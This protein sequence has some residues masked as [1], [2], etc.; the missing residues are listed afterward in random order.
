MAIMFTRIT[1]LSRHCFCTLFVLGTLIINACVEPALVAAADGLCGSANTSHYLETPTAS[2]CSLG[3]ASA[4]TGI[5]PWYWTCAGTDGGAAARCEAVQAGGVFYRSTDGGN[6]WTGLATGIGFNSP[7][8]AIAPSPC[9]NNGADLTIFIGA[10]DGAYKSLDGG[11]SWAKVLSGHAVQALALSPGFCWDNTQFAGFQLSGIYKSSDGGT[12]WSAANN[13]LPNTLVRSLAISPGFTTDQTIFA[14]ILGLGVYKSTNGGG[15]WSAANTGLSGLTGLSLAISPAYV[16]DQTLFVATTNGQFPNP[17][18]HLYRSVDGGA[19]WALADTGLAGSIEKIAIPPTFTADQ[20]V[21]AATAN[22]IYK[23]T[24]SGNTWVL[25]KSA[26][27]QTMLAVSPPYSI[28]GTVFAGIYGDNVYRSNDGGSS[29]T[30][31][32]SNF[33]TIRQLS[34]LAL[35][36]EYFADEIVF[37]AAYFAGPQLSVSAGSLNYGNVGTGT[38]STSQQVTITNGQF[39][40]ANL[41]ISSITVTGTGASQFTIAPGSCG[42]LTPILTKG[43]Q[44]TLNVTFAPTANGSANATLQINSNAVMPPT[45][46]VALNGTGISVASIINTP[47]INGNSVIV[48]GTASSSAGD[49]VALVELSFNGGA[50][51]QAASGTTSW[52]IS[53]TLPDGSYTVKS[54]A[55]TSTGIVENPGSGVFVTTPG[56]IDTQAPSG[57]LAL[58]YGVWTLNANARDPGAMCLLFYP[59]ICGQLEMSLNGSNWQPA[60]TT[61]GTGGPLWLRDRAGNQAYI[62][63]GVVWNDN[64]GPIRIDGGTYYSL[65]QHAVTAAASGNIIKLTTTPYSENLVTATTAA[66]TIRGG[67]DSSHNTV[68][69]TTPLNGSLTVQAGALTVENLDVTGTVAIEGGAVTANAITIQ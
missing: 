46:N 57:T 27:S 24:N 22:G 69:G 30:P 6:T 62:S 1:A 13:G 59:S 19:S 39:G 2:L 67:Y 33:A 31:S 18:Y 53:L 63:S 23:S 40:D 20:T 56:T 10:G 60:T 14:G 5:G 34:A 50:T 51:W 42:T 43:G 28:G 25:T 64:G 48:S 47:Y 68:T 8:S 17:V 54:R 3:A 49:S 29:W 16:S 44:C 52:S 32:S 65:L 41:A 55:T 36:P 7:I 58:Y 45:A 61:P 12:A 35:S 9:F 4:V 11:D 38:S 15:T 66:L 26:A 37:A 21:F